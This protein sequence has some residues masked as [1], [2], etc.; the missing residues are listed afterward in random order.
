MCPTTGG[1][2]VDHPFTFSVYTR[3]VPSAQNIIKMLLW[4]HFVTSQSWRKGERAIIWWVGA[5]AGRVGAAPPLAP[6]EF[7]PCPKFHEKSNCST[8]L[9]LTVQNFFNDNNVADGKLWRYVWTLKCPI[10]KT[11]LWLRIR[12]WITDVV[13]S[14]WV[15]IRCRLHWRQVRR[16]DVR[17]SP[18][19]FHFPLQS[20]SP[21]TGFLQY[22]PYK[23]CL[24]ELIRCTTQYMMRH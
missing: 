4:P 3:H 19:V 9:K 10:L 7:N 11:F 8:H 22:I 16:D 17:S 14:D 23:T 1:S 24:R 2:G 13:F 6:T 15:H 20:P 18:P 5:L 12:Q 21:W